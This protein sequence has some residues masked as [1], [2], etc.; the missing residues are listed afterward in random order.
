MIRYIIL[1]DHNGTIHRLIDQQNKIKDTD[2]L[3]YKGEKY[4]F[5]GVSA[6]PFED[7]YYFRKSSGVV[8]I[9]VDSVN[10]IVQINHINKDTQEI[11][12]MTTKYFQLRVGNGNEGNF[13]A[14]H[15]WKKV[16]VEI[17]EGD[18]PF[19]ALKAL[20]CNQYIVGTKTRK[21]ISKN[22]EIDGES[23][24]TIY[25]IIHEGP[26]GETDMGSAWLTCEFINCTEDK[27]EIDY[28]T[29]EEILDRGA[30]QIYR[31]ACK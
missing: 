29:L 24:H 2:V 31:N 13:P 14:Y 27:D 26:N 17:K 12:A 5:S 21:Y 22:M 7:I 25:G 8:N 1:K 23:D 6:S 4:F 28:F 15:I 9:R 3:E 20:V 11:V 10:R 30:K 16:F 18:D 19:A